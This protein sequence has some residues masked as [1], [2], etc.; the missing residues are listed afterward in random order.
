MHTIL[1]AIK[2]YFTSKTNYRVHSPFLF[3]LVSKVI[4]DRYFYA[5]D[6][7]EYLREQLLASKDKMQMIDLGAGSKKNN[8]EEKPISTVAKNSL[9]TPWQCQMMFK[10]IEHL[11]CKQI[12]EIGSSLGI[13]TIYLA[14]ANSASRVYSLEGNHDSIQIAKNMASHAKLK[15][16]D[17]VEGNFDDTLEKVLAQMSSVDFA[18]VDGN[19]RYEAT[20]SY[21]KKILSSSHNLTAIVIDDIYWSEGMTKAWEEL[22]KLKAVTAS[23]DFFYYGVLFLNPDIKEPKHLKII[24]A[25]LK[26]WQKY[27]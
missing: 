13:S 8:N 1:Q 26:P 10:I 25:K 24:E 19:H 14:K 15:N 12:L 6:E 11:N 9:S 18:F 27:I 16:I 2:F 3:A 17:F 23:L 4:D 7:A 20:V 21:T 5:F 22:K